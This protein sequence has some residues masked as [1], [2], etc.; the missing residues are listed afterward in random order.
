MLHKGLA[1]GAQR[2]MYLTNEASHGEAFAPLGEPFGA[3][4]ELLACS[5]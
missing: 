1:L 2:A 5:S 3:D 4:R